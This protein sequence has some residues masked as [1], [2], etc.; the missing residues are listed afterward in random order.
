MLHLH[1]YAFDLVRSGGRSRGKGRAYRVGL[2]RARKTRAKQ[3]APH[4]RGFSV[5][6]RLA[7][8]GDY[9]ILVSLYSTCLR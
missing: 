9:L 2:E 5:A 4:V 8:T 6:V 1:R 7:E 3:K